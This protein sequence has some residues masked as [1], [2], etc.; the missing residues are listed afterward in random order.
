MSRKRGGVTKNV[1]K[2][3]YVSQLEGGRGSNSY[4][5]FSHKTGENVD[6]SEWLLRI[7]SGKL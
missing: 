7:S 2:L 5:M 6:N 1:D 3:M 4:E